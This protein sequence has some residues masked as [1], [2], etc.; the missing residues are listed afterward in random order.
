MYVCTQGCF[1]IDS[2]TGTSAQDAAA[3]ATRG[4]VTA[5]VFAL[6]QHFYLRRFEEASFLPLHVRGIALLI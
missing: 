1:E 2:S 5:V 4:A 6:Q 3:M